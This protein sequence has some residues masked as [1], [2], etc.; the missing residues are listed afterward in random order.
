MES[1]KCPN[2][3][4]SLTGD[5]YRHPAFPQPSDPSVTIWR[6]MDAWKFEWLVAN[7]RL[8]MPSASR[9][10]DPF[11]GTMPDGEF[12]WWNREAANA[13]TAEK[14]GIIE[15]NRSFLSRMAQALRDQYYVGCWHMNSHENS[16]M[17]ECYTTSPEAVAVKTS[18]AALRAA[19]P[20]YVQMGVVRYID[21]ATGR[22]PSL[23]MFEYIMHKDKYY[24]FEQ[25]VRAVGVPPAVKE[26]GLEDFIANR[27]ELES[28]PGFLVYAP[29]VDLGKLIDGV[30]LHPNASDTFT[31]R[32]ADL[33]STHNLSPPERSRR[34]RTPSF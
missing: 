10:S 27:F 3:A 32:V 16:A 8:L 22:L 2:P 12:E 19:L 34:T 25:E 5:P 33:C 21:Y 15:Y 26:L 6:Y 31:Q 18:Y 17:W 13:G 11:E 4:C 23:N 9:F 29:A 30:V 14:R 7:E 24:G 1:T 20:A 28:I